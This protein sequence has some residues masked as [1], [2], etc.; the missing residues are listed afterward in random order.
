M[1]INMEGF[2]NGFE[3]FSGFQQQVLL[4]FKI[5]I[6]LGD[7]LVDNQQMQTS[8]Q[9]AEIQFKQII[10]QLAN[11]P[12]PMKARISIDY[13]LEDGKMT[14]DSIEFTNKVWDNAHK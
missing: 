12:R 2:F 10:M 5:Q 9:M 8:E 13:Q 1:N 3:E 6:W 14:E 4:L 7:A 11:D